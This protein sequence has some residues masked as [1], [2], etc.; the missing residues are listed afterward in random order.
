MRRAD[1]R[2]RGFESRLSPGGNRHG[3]EL[4]LSGDEVLESVRVCFAMSA[5]AVSTT[6]FLTRYAIAEASRWPPAERRF[7]LNLA[8]TQGRLT[9]TVDW[10]E[11][12][13]GV[14]F[15]LHGH[16]AYNILKSNYKL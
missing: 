13:I 11:W 16:T 9:L 3:H 10:E 1:P 2:G 15:V 8:H 4:P 6:S 14:Q 5:F 12:K 7:R